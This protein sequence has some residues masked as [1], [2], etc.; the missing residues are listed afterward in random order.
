MGF[1]RQEYWSGLPFPSPGDLPSRDWTHTSCVSCIAGRFFTTES[2]GKPHPS[3]YFRPFTPPEG[4]EWEPEVPCLPWEPLFSLGHPNFWSQ[5][6]LLELCPWFS[7]PNPAHVSG[8]RCPGRVVGRD[9]D[10]SQRVLLR[11]P[12]M[13][14]LP[15]LRNLG[16]PLH[17]PSLCSC[18]RVYSWAPILDLPNTEV[19][20]VHPLTHLQS[21]LLVTRKL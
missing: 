14:S 11:P 18:P 21:W 19:L 5:W 8:H 17:F 9:P 1:R 10:G 12:G 2:L 4:P 7:H 6:P 13:G 15:L 20:P 3:L 16:I